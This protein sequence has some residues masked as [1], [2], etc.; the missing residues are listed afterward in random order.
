M[1]I[2]GQKY[3]FTDLEK[4]KLKN[5]FNNVE[6]IIYTNRDIADVINEI[7]S[8]L[9]IS[10]SKIIVLNTKNELS[11][12]LIKYLTNLQFKNKINFMSIEVFLE[13]YLFK[14]YIPDNNIDLHFFGEIKSY[15]FFQYIQKRI[16]DYIGVFTLFL[17]IWPILIYSA[18]KIKK[19]SPGNVI[20]RQSRYSK[21]K[22]IFKCFKMRS[23]HLNCE[24]DPYTREN[25]IR[26]FKWGKFMRKARVDELPQLFN[27]LKGDMHF[28]G[29]RAEW[30]VLVK[31]YENII[32]YYN[33]RHL[34]SPGITGWAQVNYPYG[35]NIED[36]K[37]K[38]MYDLYYIKNWNLFL[39]FKIVYKTIFIILN[40]K[41]L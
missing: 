18:F 33:E 30:N 19:E 31:N 8:L 2:L 6:Q 27:V 10:Q 25:D 32:P 4:L 22:K 29:P 36:T 35:Q 13:K 11:P 28:I 34:V 40:K 38:L 23:M 5:N 41:G 7:K 17:L 12:K 9:A 26:I 20:F 16:I 21:N 3:K 24:H 14:C 1:I 15:S 39:E 37:Q